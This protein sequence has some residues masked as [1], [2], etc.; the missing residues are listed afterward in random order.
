[1]QV[2]DLV[3]IVAT[4]DDKV[5]GCG[6]YLGIGHRGTATTKDYLSF[7]WRGRIA[8]FDRPFWRFEVLR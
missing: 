8:T 4:S 6:V 1:M 3:W 2:G 7:L 5:C